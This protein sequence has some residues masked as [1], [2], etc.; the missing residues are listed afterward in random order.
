[1]MR[2]PRLQPQLDKANIESVI[3]CRVADRTVVQQQECCIRTAAAA[4]C[5]EAHVES[6]DGAAE[7][8]VRGSEDGSHCSTR[9]VIALACAFCGCT[10]RA[11]VFH[12]AGAGVM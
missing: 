9:T 3:M 6:D 7:H 10:C 2:K 11:S 8:D 1:M 4:H 5:E 12:E